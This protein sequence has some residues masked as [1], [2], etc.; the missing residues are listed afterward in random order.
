MDPESSISYDSDT[1]EIHVFTDAGRPCRPLLIVER[2]RIVLK[3]YQIK[4]IRNGEYYLPQL[5]EISDDCVLGVIIFNG[6]RPNVVFELGY[7]LGNE[8]P[9][10]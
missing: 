9:I 4:E 7:L 10:K 1:K 8:K 2:G 6:F 5:K 3:K